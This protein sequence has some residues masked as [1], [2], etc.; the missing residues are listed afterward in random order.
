MPDCKPKL[1]SDSRTQQEGRRH[2]RYRS[3]YV[4][5]S[6]FDRKKAVLNREQLGT[7]MVTPLLPAM[8]G[9]SSYRLFQVRTF[10]ISALLRH[11]HYETLKVSESAT[12]REIKAG[13]N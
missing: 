11:T 9:C 2:A 8:P 6:T 3:K 5:K 12:K 7:T 10:S 4:T 13:N 1:I